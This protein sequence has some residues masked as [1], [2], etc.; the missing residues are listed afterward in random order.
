MRMIELWWMPGTFVSKAL[1]Q[2][3]NEKFLRT[4]KSEGK[5]CI[6]QKQQQQTIRSLQPP[7][8]L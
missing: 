5:L 3:I 4:I 1:L 8:C 2:E 7:I 6:V